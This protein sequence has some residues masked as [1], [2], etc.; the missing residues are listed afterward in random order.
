VGGWGVGGGQS[1]ASVGNS[2][3]GKAKLKLRFNFRFGPKQVLNIM[4]F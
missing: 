4:Q 1:F 2:G 3:R